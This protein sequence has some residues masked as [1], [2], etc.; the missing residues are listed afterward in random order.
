MT[1]LRRLFTEYGQSPWLDNLSRAYRIANYGLYLEPVS[2][3]EPL[4]CRLQGGCS[5]I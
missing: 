5:A 4:T 2:G 1:K 3:I